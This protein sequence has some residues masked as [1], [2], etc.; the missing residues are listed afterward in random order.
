MRQKVV[1]RVF[2]RKTS[3]SP[4]DPLAF[5]GDPPKIP[6]LID[7]V[8]V[9]V[10][11]TYDLPRARELKRSWSHVAPVR[12]GGPA[13][14]D[15]GGF[16]VPGM[17]LKKGYT[18]TSR[19]C[20]NQ[21]WFCDVWKREGPT[22][23]LPIIDGWNLLDSN[24][25]ACSDQHIKNVFAMLN[26]QRERIHITGGLEAARLLPWH[27]DL[28]WEIRPKQMFFA[29]D[30]PC[31]LEPLVEAGRLLRLADFTRSHLRCYVL[32][33]HP[34]DRIPEAEKRLV[35]AWK[36]GFM[37]FAM[38]WKNKKGETSKDW[39]KFQRLWSRP[40]LTKKIIRKI[41]FS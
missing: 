24:I 13:I 21:C 41:V 23:E 3:A 18:I 31:D 37:P 19:G 2:P 7:E 22:R 12:I 16:F 38:L 28:L 6:P 10:A 33:G 11:F 39:R 26:N 8:H 9:S 36:A 4:D 1:A 17:Y 29:Y 32:I 27:V 14:G 15:I 25:L 34:K 35:E 40:A 20:P 5:F 30:E